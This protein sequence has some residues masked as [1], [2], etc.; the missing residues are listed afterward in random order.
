[1]HCISRLCL[2]CVCATTNLIFVLSF[3]H[4]PGKIK[5]PSGTFEWSRHCEPLSVIF[6]FP[7]FSWA[8][9]CSSDNFYQSCDVSKITNGNLA[10]NPILIRFALS[11]RPTYCSHLSRLSRTIGVLHRRWHHV[12]LGDKRLL[13]CLMDRRSFQRKAFTRLCWVL[14][15]HLVKWKAT[16][17]RDD[18][19]NDVVVGS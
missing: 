13:T 5:S 11:Q 18:L 7:R 12:T 19:L 1:M 8:L 14:G 16:T 17:C 15:R 3:H 4:L 10:W 2:A 6:C 9:L